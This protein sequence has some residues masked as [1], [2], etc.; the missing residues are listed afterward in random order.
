MEQQLLN[1]VEQESKRGVP[2]QL[3]RKALHDAGWGDDQIEEAFKAVQ[4][5]AAAIQPVEPALGV[6]PDEE[7]QILNETENLEKSVKKSKKPMLAAISVFASLVIVI[8]LLIVY[9]SFSSHPAVD[10]NVENTEPAAPAEQGGEQTIPP[11]GVEVKESEPTAEEDTAVPPAVAPTNE[12]SAVPAT[13]TAPAADA[14]TVRD[15][16]R[17]TDMQ[18]LVAA[19]KSWFETNKKYYTCG[20]SGGDCKGKLYGYPSQIG[21]ALAKTPLDSLMNQYTGKKAVCGRDY[22]YCGLNNASYSQF[23]CYYAKL[24]GGGY[25]TA[26]HGGNFKRS[27]PPKIF[28]ECAVAN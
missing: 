13:T 9:Y 20:L 21:T 23:F 10:L 12:T 2:E 16:Q 5:K 26:S 24:E 22:I 7:A 14:V 11:A 6:S 18:A 28:E 27:T 25:Y 4:S 1:Y 15:N 17:M 8:G 19:Q 3:I